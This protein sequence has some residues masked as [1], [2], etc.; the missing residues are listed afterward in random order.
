VTALYVHV[1]FCTRRCT[2][3]DFDFEVG[4]TPATATYVD[5]L[6]RELE[7]RADELPATLRTIYLGGGTPSI[8]G[9][10]G[11]DAIARLLQRWTGAVQ[12]LTVELN[13]E[14]VDADLVAALRR[15]GT[16]RV[17]LGVQSFEPDALRQL[18]R[19]HDAEAAHRAVTT[20]I[21]AGFATSIDLIVGWPGQ[22]A[23]MLDRDLDRLLLLGVEH[24]S[25]YA[26]TI[27][28]NTAWPKLVR[29]GLRVLPDGDAQADALVQCE[30]RLV[31]AGL[32]HYEIASYARPGRRAQHN[33]TYWAWRDYV[34]VGPSAASA[35]YAKDGSVTRRTNPRGLAAWACGAA[36]ETERLDPIAAAAE[37]LWLALRTSDGVDL[38]AFVARFTEVDEA[39]V[40]ARTRRRVATGDL[41]W[42][43]RRVVVA[44][45]RWL[46][47]D[48][49]AADVLS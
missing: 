44:P 22:T 47:L 15:L 38:D 29:R 39:W 5:A 26:L 10:A 3:C 17:S 40:R 20:C 36:A 45:G 24:V 48:A 7:T 21:A 41:L 43:D 8:V 2:Y 14:H 16:T 34:G 35:S 33:G 9:P 13:P 46:V 30:A 11:L 31:A 19:A 23:A 37:G 27:E 6:A 4:R 49:I 1:P 28:A 18:G 42:R 32:E 25:I 12:E